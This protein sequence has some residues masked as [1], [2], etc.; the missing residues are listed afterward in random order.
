MSRRAGE[1]SKAA[2]IENFGAGALKEGS[3]A[4]ASCGAA[5]AG[6]MPSRLMTM[7]SVAE[8]ERNFLVLMFLS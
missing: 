4:A 3:A 2:G 7:I 5:A 1:T 8:I 6:N